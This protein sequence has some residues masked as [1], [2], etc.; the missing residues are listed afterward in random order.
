MLAPLKKVLVLDPLNTA[1]IA[2]LESKGFAVDLKVDKLE[3][4]ELCRIIGGY[5]IVCL[6]TQVLTKEVL[7]GANRLQAIAFF[8]SLLDQIDLKAALEMGIPVFTAPYQHQGSVCEFLIAS[9][10]LLSRQLGDRNKEIHSGQWIKTS[11][12]CHE[13]RGKTLG[14]VGY[15]HVG[16]QLGVMAEALSLKVI[17]YDTL[18]IMPIG[19]ANPV[20]SLKEL[21]QA[22]DFIAITVSSS[23]ENKGLIGH[24]E[25]EQTKKGCYIL[26]ACCG[27]AIDHA[28]IANA[29]KSGH[30]AGAG[31]DAWPTGVTIH[32]SDLVQLPNVILTPGIAADTIEAQKRC[33]YEVTN[34]AISYIE[35][36]V[37]TG[38]LNFPS[39]VTPPLKS[40]SRRIVCIY[41]NVR[42]V[43]KA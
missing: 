9:I 19:L 42:G 34:A 21:L 6:S 11:S 5:Q 39:V 23:M 2:H 43:L 17:F 14:I 38:S 7:H 30:L 28:A 22:S 35:T 25:I 13:V 31:I 36:G 10:I 40:G 26:N 8:G 24:S 1:V 29:I 33:M 15:G 18:S 4:A 41:R 20:N 32:N 3:E 27:D 37:S 12:N 16:A